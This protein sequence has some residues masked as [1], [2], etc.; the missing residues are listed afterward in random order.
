M[1]QR[2]DLL[3]LLALFA[4]LVGFTILGPGRSQDNGLSNKTT[5]HSSGTGGTMALLRWT[6][7]LGYD[8]RRLQYTD[9]EL[10]EQAAALFILNPTE[11]I[12]RQHAM[13]VLEWVESGGTLILADDRTSFFGET[14][15][16][17]AELKLALR[18]YDEAAEDAEGGIFDA[19]IER[20][21]VLQPIL[22]T[23]PLQEVRVQTNQFIEV[24]REDVARLIGLGDAPIL[25][26][27]RQG[28]G[29]IYVSSATHPFTNAGLDDE[30]NADLVLNLLRRV[31]DGGRILFDEYHHGFFTPPSL[32]SVVLSNPWGWA[33]VYALAV[34]VAYLILTG[35]RF[36]QPVPLREEVALRSSAEYVES[37]ADLFQRAGKRNFVRQHYYTA[38]KRRLARPYGINP[39]L[40]DADF[41]AELSRQRDVDATVLRG[42]LGRLRQSQMSEE[43][44]L[45]AIAETDAVEVKRKT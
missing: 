35:R 10:D 23:P 30:R 21:P 12:S 41:V 28:Q 13:T 17:L 24:E 3:I 33:L 5:T 19:A 16:L 4:A 37:M 34:L 6:R 22:N 18:I 15:E 27:I 36:G 32:R 2:R 43:A 42:L 1:K 38:F 26:G 8:A 39:N 45:R 14:E 20:A 40:D 31:P 29:Y 44:L 7:A 25:V 11:R 9:F